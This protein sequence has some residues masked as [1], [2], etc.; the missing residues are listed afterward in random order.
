MKGLKLFVVFSFLLS[1]ASLAGIGVL[2]QRL[3]ETQALKEKLESNQVQL[4]QRSTQLESQ[5]GQ[6]AKFQQE[7]ERLREQMKGYVSQ[8]DAAKK[9]VE[10][11]FK[12]M[13]VLRKKIKAL[14]AE[15]GILTE[16]MTIGEE[17]EKAIVREAVKVPVTPSSAALAAAPT[18][19]PH[20]VLSVNRQ[21][22]FVVVNVGLRNRLKI[23]DTLRV[24]ESGKLIGR[25]QV[26]KLYETLSACR[27]LVENEPFKIKEG[28]LVR[29]A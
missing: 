6:S 4:E 25:I 11:V 17:T 14:E 28:D 26:E 3:Q 27:I 24:E 12:D 8:R 22:Q 2:Y 1:V 13:S 7:V 9:E 29:V 16:E 10:Q 21:F 23:G 5:A 19:R 18:E 15:K 20:Q